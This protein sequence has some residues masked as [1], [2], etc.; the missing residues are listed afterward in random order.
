MKVLFLSQWYPN[1]YDNMFGLFVQKHAEAV[2]L[3]CDVSVLYVHADDKIKE[4][5]IVRQ[6]QNEV[7]EYIVYYPVRTKGFCSKIRKLV[8]FTK[9]YKKG[10]DELKKIDWKPDI[11]HANVLTRT[12]FVAFVYKKITA[13]PYV[14][15]EHW[16][17]LLKVQDEFKGQLRRRLAKLVVKEAGYI[18]PVSIELKEGLEYNNLLLTQCRIVENV[19]DICFYKTYPI[20]NKYKKQI[21]NVTCFSENHKNIFGLLRV[22]KKI[23]EH[24]NDFQL[25]LIGTGDDFEMTYDYYESLDIPEEIVFFAGLKTSEEVAELMHNVD[26]IVQFSNYES[27]GVVVQEALVSGKPVVSTK[28]G[29]ATD[30]INN[31][32]GLLID[33]KDEQQLFTSI[34]YMLDN[35]DKYNTN[36]IANNIS[37]QFSYK[38]IGRK[39]QEVYCEVLKEDCE[40]TDK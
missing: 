6:Q 7:T 18:L 5:E 19:V 21:L 32:N 34:E 24:R 36:E 13:T 20:N 39:F 12:P 17:R 1:R 30:Y 35:I 15:T 8:N 22:V 28:V 38:T 16:T 23:T 11:L 2:S 29:I 4:F 9:A 10:F 37:E 40:R 14:I 27:A 31:S 3:Y 25:I 33:V 26:F